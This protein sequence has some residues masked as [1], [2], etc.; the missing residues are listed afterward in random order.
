MSTP[1]SVLVLFAHPTYRSS[2]ANRILRESV[3][4]L[5]GV[6]FHDLY[7]QYPDFL[8]DVKREQGLLLEHDL[9]VFQHPL[10]WY[11]SPAILKLWQD[12]VLEYNWAYGEKGT[13]LR[14]KAFWSVVTTGGPEDA[15]TPEGHNRIPVRSYLSPFEQ[16]AL[17]CGMRYL[18]PF[19]VHGSSRLGDDVLVRHGATYRARVTGFL[20]QGELP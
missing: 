14:G 11:S 6:T 17:L 4:G 10:Y 7:A 2:R 13:H 20:E 15:Y 3:E 18:D 1:R 19:I 16:M 12:E 9:V 5:P 8:V